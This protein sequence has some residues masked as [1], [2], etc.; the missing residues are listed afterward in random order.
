[1]TVVGVLPEVSLVLET[2]VAVSGGKMMVSSMVSGMSR[3]IGHGRA[4]MTV[5][6]AM[7]KVLSMAN[8]DGAVGHPTAWMLAG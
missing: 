2:G 8:P 7:R 4:T 5:G 1:M 3:V 6:V